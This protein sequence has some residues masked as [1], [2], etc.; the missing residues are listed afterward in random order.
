MKLS[1]IL[2]LC[3]QEGWEITN[4]K[5]HVI[6]HGEKLRVTHPFYVYLKFYRDSP[7]PDVRY[8]S[9]LK[10][11]DLLWPQYVFTNNEWMRERF[12]IHCAEG[13]NGAERYSQ[14]VFTSGA[15]TGKSMDCAK[16][17]TLFWLSDPRANACIIASTTIE[18]VQSRIW[19]YVNMLLNETAFDVPF[20]IK[21][22]PPKCMYPSK[23]GTQ[24][25][26][27]HGMFAVAAKEGTED[28]AVR[29]LIGR[30]PKKR[31][32]IVLDECTDLNLNIAAALPNL[33][34]GVEICQTI[35]VGN[36]K[37]RDDLHGSMATPEEGWDSIN[38]DEHRQWYTKHK[39]GICLFFHP[40]DS[41]AIHEPDPLKKQALSKFL[42]TE[43]KLAEKKAAHGDKSESYYRF[44]IGFWRDQTIERTVIS[45]KFL[46]E[47]RVNE[48]VHWS[49]YYTLMPV[50]GLDAATKTESKG[51]VLRVG[52]LGVDIKGNFVLDFSQ[53][54]ML[55]YIHISKRTQES[56]EMQLCKQVIHWLEKYQC[57]LQ[58]LA[59][60]ST[61]LGRMC[62]SL[63]RTVYANMYGIDFTEVPSPMKI[64]STRSPNSKV[65]EDPNLYVIPPYDQWMLVRDFCAH[66]Q[67]KGLDARTIKQMCGRQLQ[68]VS[69]KDR[70]EKK[71]DY[72]ARM[73][74]SDPA[75]ATSPDEADAL[76]LAVQ[77][78]I[79]RRGF[80]KGMRAEV[81]T[82]V[83]VDDFI[84]EKM[85]AFKQIRA[86]E[87]QQ[88][89][90]QKKRLVIPRASFS[91]GWSPRSGKGRWSG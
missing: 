62:G 84:N 72:I 5:R 18:A 38:P 7:I 70:L 45:E 73:R 78:A 74:I 58:Y 42:I 68:N 53:E 13:R 86:E 51:C 21:G 33:E 19:G 87:A 15:G 75:Y 22:K 80:K 41:P 76:A 39:N 24:Q 90:E 11:H 14:I 71:E 6:V 60:D 8:Q 89:S 29:D 16:I 28:R 63:I 57:S 54:E 9:L 35:A 46:K 34:Q 4:D 40:F 23:R 2:E 91:S 55:H 17:A 82:E 10:A 20:Q 43:E 25:D 69:G 85:R 52:V 81:L 31:I 47:N 12:Y 65:M 61:G 27:I 67:I 50:A 49:G 66:G 83:E 79:H 3:A 1:H 77:V 26:Q 44:V 36:A 64:L 30:H 59:I 37:D 48:R 56:A 32:L 88:Q